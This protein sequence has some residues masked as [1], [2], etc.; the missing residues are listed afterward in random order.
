MIRVTVEIVPHGCEEKRGRICQIEIWNTLR[1]TDG[2]KEYDYV[3]SGRHY[4][5]NAPEGYSGTVIRKPFGGA[6]MLLQ[7]VLAD[8]RGQM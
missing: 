8:I 7:D 1:G 5:D 3:F 6:A 4:P 2:N